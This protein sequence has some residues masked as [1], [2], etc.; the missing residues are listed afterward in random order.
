[1]LLLNFIF[2]IRCLHI[3]NVGIFDRIFTGL[4]GHGNAIILPDTVP[5]NNV[6]MFLHNSTHDN[7]YKS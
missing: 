3:L 2:F 4:F 5:K 1:M 6:P 7:Y